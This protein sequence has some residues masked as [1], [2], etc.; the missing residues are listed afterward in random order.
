MRLDDAE[1][2]LFDLA[3]TLAACRMV[4]ID[5]PEQAPLL[6][7][8]DPGAAAIELGVDGWTGSA[9]PSCCRLFGLEWRLVLAP[10]PR[11]GVFGSLAGAAAPALH[12]RI[13][14]A[15]LAEAISRLAAA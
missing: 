12:S 2:G 7:F 1:L 4:V 11:Y 13:D 15:G 9:V 14:L 5:D 3:A 8:C 10:P 6:G